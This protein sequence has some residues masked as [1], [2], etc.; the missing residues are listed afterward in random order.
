[1]RRKGVS[2]A[3]SRRL[4]LLHTSDIHIGDENYPL[5]RQAGLAMAVDAAIEAGVDAMLIAGDLFDSARVRPHDVEAAWAQIARVPVP[6]ILIPGNHDCLGAPS[7]YSRISHTDAGGHVHFLREP[8]G[9]RLVLHELGLTTWARGMVEHY[10]ANFPLRGYSRLDDGNWQVVMAHGHYVPA[11]EESYRSSPIP[12]QQIAALHCD[13]LALG[14]WHRFQDVSAGGTRA[15]YCG[16]PAEPGMTDAST[17]L[18]T[19]DPADGVTVERITLPVYTG[20]MR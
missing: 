20:P 4:R 3:G 13:Y 19:L 16:S 5:L 11:N 12:E 8:D 18:V 7:I 1:M 17:N 6:V 14:H 15:Y 9:E 10:P 2:L